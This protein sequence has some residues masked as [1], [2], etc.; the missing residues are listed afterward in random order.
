MLEVLVEET[1]SGTGQLLISLIA[2]FYFDEVCIA[3]AQFFSL[4]LQ[5]GDWSNSR[6]QQCGRII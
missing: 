5:A 1:R 4:I 3:P 2:A 6:V